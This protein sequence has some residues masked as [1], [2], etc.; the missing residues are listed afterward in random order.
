[1]ERITSRQNAIVKLFREA[2]AGGSAA[3]WMLLDGEHL[4]AEALASSVMLEVL[5]L[6]DR[7]AEH[8]EDLAAQAERS[9][10]RVVAVND[11]V[12][13]ALSPVQQPSGVVA[14]AR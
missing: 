8:S 10:A 4:V 1:M 2:A 5:A 7:R 13:K 11:Q 12:L 14:L 9:G 6:G 3:E